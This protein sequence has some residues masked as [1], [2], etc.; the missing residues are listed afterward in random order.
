MITFITKLVNIKKTYPLDKS[1]F[2][3]LCFIQNI[4]ILFG[5]LKNLVN[6]KLQHKTPTINNELI[7]SIIDD[8]IALTYA[9]IVPIP[10]LINLSDMSKLDETRNTVI[11]NT[12]KIIDNTTAITAKKTIAIIFLFLSPFSLTRFNIAL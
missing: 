11:F 7:K 3:L 4:H 12:T 1:F 6:C 5:L 10:A 8:T 2:D 9:K